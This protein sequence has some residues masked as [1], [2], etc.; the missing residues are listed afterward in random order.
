VKSKFDCSKAY[1]SGL[2]EK[3]GYKTK[4]NLILKA[5]DSEDGNLNYGG[6]DFEMEIF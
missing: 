5:R 6:E 2:E 3:Y 1:L 4:I